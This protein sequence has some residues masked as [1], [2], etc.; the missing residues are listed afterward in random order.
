MLFRNTNHVTDQLNKFQSGARLE[1][2]VHFA[3]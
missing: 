3:R 2:A 1:P